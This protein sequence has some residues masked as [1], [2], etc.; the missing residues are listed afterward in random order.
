MRDRGRTVRERMG[1]DFWLGESR[2]NTGEHRAVLGGRRIEAKDD[3]AAADIIRK[4]RSEALRIQI[5]RG[6]R[7][8]V[9]GDSILQSPLRPTRGGQNG[10]TVLMRPTT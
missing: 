6:A 10:D 3:L 8:R 2:V 5:C 1:E 9:D 4:P 7:A